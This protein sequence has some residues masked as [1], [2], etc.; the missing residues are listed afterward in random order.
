MQQ[1]I[2]L[3]RLPAGKGRDVCKSFSEWAEPAAVCQHDRKVCTKQ[4]LGRTNKLIKN[5]N[6]VRCV[7]TNKSNY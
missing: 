4:W 7:R 2:K 1:K 6:F 5:R 3:N